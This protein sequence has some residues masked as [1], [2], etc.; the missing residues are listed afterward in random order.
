[1]PAFG[2]LLSFQNKATDLDKEILAQASGS[3][4]FCDKASPLYRWGILGLPGGWEMTQEESPLSLSSKTWA[5][6]PG[7][8]LLV[9]LLSK[10]FPMV[11]E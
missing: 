8:S 4:I 11:E 5:G 9:L 2:L 6:Y 1:M 10:S 3:V 7:F